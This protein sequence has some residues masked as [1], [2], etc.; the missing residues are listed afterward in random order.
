MTRIA[1]HRLRHLSYTFYFQAFNPLS[2]LVERVKL[3][4]QRWDALKMSTLE[5]AESFQNSFCFSSMTKKVVWSSGW[6]WH[7]DDDDGS[8]KLWKISS[9]LITRVSSTNCSG[10]KICFNLLQ[11][12]AKLSPYWFRQIFETQY[13]YS[14]CDP[15]TKINV[16]TVLNDSQISIKNQRLA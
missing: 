9:A 2:C 4:L 5:W 6:S 8:L 1:S 7:S 15:L 13:K 10:R 3:I 16:F 14:I 12:V 11:Y